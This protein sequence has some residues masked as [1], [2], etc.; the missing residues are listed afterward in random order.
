M[1]NQ[2]NN[3][4]GCEFYKQSTGECLCKNL[5]YNE[6]PKTNFCDS[7]QNNNCN[8]KQLQ[9]EL[10]KNIRLQGALEKIVKGESLYDYCTGSCSA[11]HKDTSMCCQQCI[12]KNALEAKY[13]L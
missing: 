12:A 11:K 10:N 7:V 1:T 3:N 2:A 5:K 13:E 6:Q 4:E 8:Y 9:R